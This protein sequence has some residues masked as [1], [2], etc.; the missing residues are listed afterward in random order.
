M[1]PS[2]CQRCFQSLLIA[3]MHI[4]NQLS[5][6]HKRGTHT[7]SPTVRKYEAYHNK[8]AK[9]QIQKKE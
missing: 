2:N 4:F 5:K 3:S 9:D 1:W 8:N 7:A 6:P